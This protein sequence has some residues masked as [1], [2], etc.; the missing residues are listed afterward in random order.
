MFRTRHLVALSSFGIVVSAASAPL[1]DC[2]LTGLKGV[3]SDAAARMIKQACENKVLAET[4]QK[5]M[6]QYGDS[7]GVALEFVDYRV[8]GEQVEVRLKN[9][10]GQT[11][12]LVEIGFG[13]PDAAGKCHTYDQ[14]FL[15]RTRIRPDSASDFLAP[16]ARLVAKDHSICVRAEAVRGRPSSWTDVN[17]GSYEPLTRR[18]VQAIN[19]DLGTAYA[20]S[21]ANSK[22]LTEILIQNLGSKK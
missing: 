2:L 21:E 22:W 17:I 14:F 9:G 13:T 1:D 15:Y 5:N 12:S 20:D 4:K 19:G 8:R 3:N 18:E 6:E 16:V 7:L 11:A 10:S